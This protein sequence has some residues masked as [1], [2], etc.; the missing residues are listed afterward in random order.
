M[1]DEHEAHS[2][3]S[4][5]GAALPGKPAAH[6]YE[7]RSMIYGLLHGTVASDLGFNESWS[8]LWYSG[9]LFWATLL[10][11]Q[12]LGHGIVASYVGLLR[13]LFGLHACLQKL[14]V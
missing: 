9:L 6:N 1:D 7:L 4:L 13:E 5:G 10:S 11:W 2:M 12:M 3:T 8:T 14:L